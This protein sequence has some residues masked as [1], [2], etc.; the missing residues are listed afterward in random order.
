[1]LITLDGTCA[2]L[3]EIQQ[4]WFQ[5]DKFNL[6]DIKQITSLNSSKLTFGGVHFV[7]LWTSYIYPFTLKS[8]NFP[9]EFDRSVFPWETHSWNSFILLRQCHSVRPFNICIHCDNHFLPYSTVNWSH[10]FESSRNW[11][12]IVLFMSIVGRS[13]H[14]VILIKCYFFLNPKSL[15][16]VCI[17]CSRLLTRSF[18]H[19]SHCV[20]HFRMIQCSFWRA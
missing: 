20:D 10:I 19:I 6:C 15:P 12:N 13:I 7:Y 9:N 2:D 4:G 17:C 1:M 14:R 3:A 11:T 5:I 18:D 16:E 8:T